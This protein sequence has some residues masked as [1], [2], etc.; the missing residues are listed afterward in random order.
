MAFSFNENDI[1]TSHN[2]TEMND[3]TKYELVI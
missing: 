2:E 3:E 1:R